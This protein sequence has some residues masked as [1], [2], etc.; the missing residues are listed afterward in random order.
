MPIRTIAVSNWRW[1]LT[2]VPKRGALAPGYA[3]DFD[4]ST[5]NTIRPKTDGD[6]GDMVLREARKRHL[7]RPRHGDGGGP[8]Q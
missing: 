8:G 2:E 5:W 7:P 4:D 3:N 1:H 6:T